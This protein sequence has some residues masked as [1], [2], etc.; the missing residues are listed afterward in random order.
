[1]EAQPSLRINRQRFRYPNGKVKSDRLLATLLLSQGTPMI[2][3]GDEFGRTQ[4]GNNNAYCQDNEVSWLDWDTTEK[5]QALIRFAKKLTR[6]RH[7]YPVLRRS[8]FLAGEYNEELGV[9]DVTWINAN[10]SEMQP[11]DWQDG[12]M[13]CFG[14][15]VDGRAQVTGIRKQGHDATLLMILNS[16]HDAVNFAL[17]E[18]PGGSV[19]ELLLDTHVPDQKGR[20]SFKFGN[21]YQVTGRSL[22]LFLMR[23]KRAAFGRGWRR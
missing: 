18:S 9:K 11:A 7:H 16:F 20:P 8:R 19:W 22:L 21:H 3:A 6:L 2:L 10:G 14:M 15:L 23:P 12:N 1:M 4:Q 5:G 17:P 13:N